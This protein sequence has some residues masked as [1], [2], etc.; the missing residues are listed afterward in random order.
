MKAVIWCIGWEMLWINYSPFFLVSQWFDNRFYSRQAQHQKDVWRQ[1]IRTQGSSKETIC[2][3]SPWWQKVETFLDRHSIDLS[4][5][6]SAMMVM[7]Q[8]KNWDFVTKEISPE[9][10][11]IQQIVVALEEV[12]GVTRNDQDWYKNYFQYE[13]NELSQLTCPLVTHLL[14]CFLHIYLAYACFC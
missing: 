6:T 13:W 3:W 2:V 4:I 12:V 5:T 11:A 8:P 14:S 1:T 10:S 9:W 7:G